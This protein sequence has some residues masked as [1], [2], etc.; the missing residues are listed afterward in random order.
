MTDHSI[1]RRFQ[2][3][4]RAHAG[5]IAVRSEAGD[6]T[7]A[8]L[9]ES[10]RT[11][12]RALM[13]LGIERGD[14]VAIWGV[15]S[16]PW[17]EAGLGI[18]AAGGTLVPI[19]TRLRG[20]EAEGILNDSGAR[21]LFCDESFGGFSFVEAILERDVPGLETIVVLDGGAGVAGKGGG[22]VI[23]M[24]ALRALADR[25]GTEA[26]DARIAQ[27]SGDDIV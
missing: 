15:N 20:R 27:A 8:E 16:Q 13:A 7:Y 23:D 19:G 3:S 9:A 6:L 2:Q 25:V 18:Q 12:G 21:I 26:L 5:R 4:A 24:A 11:L 22:K 17:V 1:Y 14:R 10:S